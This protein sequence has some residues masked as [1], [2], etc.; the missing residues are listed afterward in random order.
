MVTD[1]YQDL[2][3]GTYMEPTNRWELRTDTQEE[4][5]YRLRN[6]FHGYHHYGGNPTCVIEL[7]NPP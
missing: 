5:F 4:A 7:P 6:S 2:S 3:F 1:H